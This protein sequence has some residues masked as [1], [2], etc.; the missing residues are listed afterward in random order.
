MITNG[1]KGNR[2]KNIKNAPVVNV[3]RSAKELTALLDAAERKIKE[4]DE[5]IQG[6]QQQIDSGAVSVNSSFIDMASTIRGKY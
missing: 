6:L 4:Q 1:Q 2:A 3:E 5:I